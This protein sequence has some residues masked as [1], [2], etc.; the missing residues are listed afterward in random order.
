[1]SWTNTSISGGQ[2]RSEVGSM[3]CLFPPDSSA[4]PPWAPV[5]SEGASFPSGSHRSPLL[6][7]F[8]TPGCCPQ[9][10][11]PAASRTAPRPLRDRHL[12]GEGWTAS[13]IGRGCVMRPTWKHRHAAQAGRAAGHVWGSGILMLGWISCTCPCWWWLR[14]QA[15]TRPLSLPPSGSR[16]CCGSPQPCTCWPL[17]D[18]AALAPASVQRTYLRVDRVFCCSLPMCWWRV[19]ISSS[20]CKLFFHSFTHILSNS[21]LQKWFIF[22]SKVLDFLLEK[23]RRSCLLRQKY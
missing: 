21:S 12:H 3:C 11:G 1:M 2:G 14:A 10:Q 23:K 5:C 22:S 17:P 20:A 8:L 4:S 7:P 16:Q 18:Q 13:C 6:M 19:E 15:S 9:N